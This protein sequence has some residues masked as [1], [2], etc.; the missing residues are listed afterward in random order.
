VRQQYA[1]NAVVVSGE[2]DWQALRGVRNVKQNEAGR[3]YTLQLDDQTKPDD[4]KLA[5]LI[6]NLVLS[7]LFQKR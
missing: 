5:T 7:D 1:E 4:Y 6:E 2:G 3:S